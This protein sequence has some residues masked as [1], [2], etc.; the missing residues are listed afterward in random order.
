MEAL[1]K[2]LTQKLKETCIK[3]RKTGYVIV[4]VM[5]SIIVLPTIIQRKPIKSLKI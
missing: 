3:Q 5:K 2:K 4:N 1:T